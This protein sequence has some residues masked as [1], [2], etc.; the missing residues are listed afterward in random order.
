VPTFAGAQI[1]AFA[2]S[3]SIFSMFL[4]LTLYL[5]NVLGYSPIQAGIRFL[6][7][8][9]LS[10]VF[11]PIAGKLSAQMP[12]RLLLGGGLGL[13]GLGLVLMH[14]ISVE[15]GWTTLLAGFI[16][17]GAG[18][19]LTNPPLASTA[20]SVVEPRR[21]G[22]ASGINSTFRQVGIAT[23]IAALGALFQHHIAS[24]LHGAP[25][26]VVR[27]VASGHVAAAGDAGRAAF[28]G[29]MNE[30]LL[31]AAGVAFAGALLSLALVRGQDFVRAPEP[32]AG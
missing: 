6:P 24:S 16:V 22:M 4:Y 30:I 9:L 21:A 26:A 20:V 7:T 29:G 32:V 3:A 11:A 15:A 2:I 23:G 19:G 25:P 13:I 1:A 12:V 31:V 8:T 14:G 27:A 17:N 10:F 5:Q 18:V 28:V